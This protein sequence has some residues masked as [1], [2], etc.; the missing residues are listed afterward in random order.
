MAPNKLDDVEI[1]DDDLE[2]Q[3][4]TK[5]AT[6]ENPVDI[7]IFNPT[8]D[9]YDMLAQDV[10]A[11]EDALHNATWSEVYEA[12]CV[13]TAREWGMVAIGVF[14]VLFFLYWF[15]F[16]LKLMGN[17]AK[18]LT[19]CTASTFFASSTN[20]VSGVIIGMVATMLL[21]SSSTTTAII[22]SLTGTVLTLDQAIYMV[23]GCNVGTTFTG[24]LVAL[25][26]IGNKDQLERVFAGACVHDMFNY[27][28]VVIF[29]PL[30]V[31]TGYLAWLTGL[32][33]SGAEA[34]GGGEEWEGP[35]KK[36]VEPLADRV[37]KSNS[38]L[39]KKVALGEA[40]CEEGG[41]FYPI[42][43]EPGEPTAATCSQTGLIS[44]DKTTNNCPLMFS[45]N[46]TYEDDKVS[47][48]VMLFLAICLLFICLAGLV[49]ILSKL[50]N[51]ISHRVIYK[52][53]SLNGY[54]LI[55][56]G[57]GITML[58]QSSSVT[59][60]AL[61]PLVGVGAIRLEQLYPL[62]L[63]ANVGT[64]ITALM[65]AMVTEGILPLQ[66]AL[67]HLMY[68]VSGIV[69]M[70]PIPM[71]RIP[72]FSAKFFGRMTRIWR[73]FPCL[74]VV[75][76]FVLVPLIVLG[77][78]AC[79]ANGGTGWLVLG[80]F[81]TFIVVMWTAWTLFSCRY[82]GGWERMIACF[83]RRESTRAMYENLP[84]DLDYL[85]E[86]VS[87][88]LEETGLEEKDENDDDDDDTEETDLKKDIIIP[89]KIA[90]SIDVSS[91]EVDC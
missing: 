17:S 33:V 36:I 21:D 48:G 2:E 26:R 52:A 27:F 71:T 50:M 4:D 70:Y 55:V 20:P 57:T 82:R 90:S 14:L 42:I 64:T 49:M 6:K 76:F 63:G 11:V 81:F 41:G 28:S 53:T 84:T 32:M 58:M 16:A 78:S 18:V 31:L 19:G 56:I 10:G 77:I 39:I 87:L 37:I 9:E 61:L 69:L 89:E 74:Y 51:A 72:I 25:S 34:D 62:A 22:V 7:N 8:A 43:C 85:K 59:T 12:C 75:F 13:H 80:V 68:N 86:K 35:A 54:A 46:A 1:N 66:V 38:G 30:E 83:Q 65:A 24:Q 47:G 3:D 45:E 79:F 73:G 67:V 91:T 44:C 29:L 5:K 88:L 60:S 23:M 40:T 15:M